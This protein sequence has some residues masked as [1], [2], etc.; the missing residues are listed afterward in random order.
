MERF[1]IRPGYGS[2]VLLVEFLGDHRGDGYPPVGAL[3]AEAL[4]AAAA[5]M[6]A[7]DRELALASDGLIS[8]WRYAGGE[9]EIDDD[10]WSLFILAPTNNQAVMADIERALIASE[11]FVKQPVDFAKYQKGPEEP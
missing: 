9:Y 3:L 8:K 10:G 5:P 6:S 4:G 7:L 2:D 1:S 11:R